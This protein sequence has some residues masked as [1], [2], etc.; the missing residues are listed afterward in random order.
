VIT[1]IALAYRVAPGGV[2]GANLLFFLLA[3]VRIGAPEDAV[4]GMLPSPTTVE[5]LIEELGY[6]T[7]VIRYGAPPVLPL[8]GLITILAAVFWGLGAALAWGLSRNRPAVALVPPILF[9]LQ[10]ATIDRG[11]PGTIWIAVALVLVT[12]A[13]LAVASDERRVAGRLRR[14]TGGMLPATSH[15]LPL[16][17]V[18]VPTMLA[19]LTMG[20]FSG[21]IDETGLIGWRRG[22]LGGGAISTGVSYNLFAGIVQK[23]L[24]AD[25]DT[26]VFRATITGMDPSQAYFRL[27]DLERFDGRHWFPRSAGIGRPA[28]GEPW[29]NPEHVQAG[30][31]RA[32]VQDITIGAL[33]MQVLPALER[34]QA[35]ATTVSIIEETYRVREDASLWLDVKTR[36][37]NSY[38]VRSE[39][40]EPD[41]GALA[42]MPNGSLSPI[43]AQAVSAGAADLRPTERPFVV[44]PDDIAEFVELPDD[45]DRRLGIQARFVTGDATTD[46]ERG[47]L[48][49]RFFLDTEAEGFTYSTAT[50]G[51]GARDLTDW[52]FEPDSPN[53]RTGYCEQFATAMAVM[54]RTIDVPSKVVLGFTPGEVVGDTVII[55]EKFAHAWVELWIAGH[56]WVRFDPTPRSDGQSAATAATA[57]VGFD[58]AQ[59]IPP[60]TD[61]ATTGA[62]AG[63]PD[64]TGNRGLLPT[65]FPLGFPLP[66]P[67][68]SVDVPAWLGLVLLS[69]LSASV[70][71]IV[72]R[73]RRGRR[74]KRLR[75][76]DIAAAWWEIVDRM[77]DL[78]SPV[79]DHLTPVEVASKTTPLLVPLANQYGRSIFGPAGSL[80]LERVEEAERSY[81]ATETHLKATHAASARIWSWLRVGSLRRR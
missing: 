73:V 41:Y 5:T 55:R 37:G 24:V 54:A 74:M 22:G 25:S 57:V 15:V 38:Q 23:G 29:G 59:H 34:P 30:A 49:E 53:Y 31:T 66:I 16:V 3:G 13:L 10:L 35:L 77:A 52:L 7:Q 60:P 46:L 18:A 45:L 81:R 42:T 12:G 44:T 47:L 62:P 64:P 20:T 70:V 8:A 27:V 75:E 58:P 33:A 2:V 76:G 36:P 6:A 61:A 50:K 9:Y 68:G 80:T 17:F 48:L 21:R 1:W 4:L 14:T 65:D 78:G 11:Y 79:S 67:G 32:A 71:P 43:F 19:M 63:P 69:A 39:I 28:A 26:E 40:A 51:H 72:K 56:G